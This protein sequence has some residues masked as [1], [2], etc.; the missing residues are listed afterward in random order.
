MSVPDTQ[1]ASVRR[2]SRFYTH[3]LG[4]LNEDLLE[5]DLSLTEA[6]V[7]YELANRSEP[8]ASEIAS[9]LNLDLGYLSRILRSFSAQGLI[10]RQPSKSDRRQNLL[11]LT[12]AGCSCAKTLAQRSSEQVRQM[13]AP[14]SSGQR[15]RLVDSMAAIESLLAPSQPTAE[16]PTA[17]NP[18]VLR[19][20]RPGDIGWVVERHGQLYSQEYGWDQRFEALVA[21]I[22][23][24]FIDQYEPERE[25]CWIAERNGQRLGSVFLVRDTE[26]DPATARL[27]LLLVDPA[28]R[29]LGLG[30]TLVQQCALF[31]RSAGYKRIV[32]WTNS[33][34]TSAR[35]IYESEGYRLLHEKPYTAFGKELV[36]QDWQLDL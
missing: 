6:R 34:L 12:E 25:H 15:E 22:A 16:I 29:G 17:A 18:I 9:S 23:A 13:L 27:R 35:R 3:L 2:F 31:A 5:S 4:V 11:P 33:V 14:L 21:R 19:S 1:I 36:S 32:L 7:L 28:A 30:R 10:R 8:T 20:H 24:D 26:S